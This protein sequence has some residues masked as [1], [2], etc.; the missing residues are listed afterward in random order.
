MAKEG[1]VYEFELTYDGEKVILT[2][3][4]DN[5]VL[6]TNVEKTGDE[7]GQGNEVINY[8]ISDVHNGSSVR[9]NNFKI[10]D[11]LPSEVRLQSIT[12]GTF[13]EDLTYKVQYTT[14][15]NNIKTIKNNLSTITDNSIDFTNEQL[16]NDEYITKFTFIFDSVK[17]NFKNTSDITVK[18]KVIEG[19]EKNSIF[20]NCV[21]V[22]GTYLNVTVEDKD[23][24]PTVVYENKIEINKAT[25][26]DNQYTNETK[27]T[28]MTGVKFDIF[29]ST[30]NEL[31]GQITTE[32]GY[33]E[34]KYLPIGSYY[35]VETETLDYYVLPENNRFKFEITKK[36]QTVILNIENDVVNLIVDV[37]KTGTVE[38]IPGGNLEYLFDIQNKSNDTVE[39]FVF[40]D[41]LPSEIRIDKIFTGTFNQKN[42]YKVQYITNNNSNWKTID[43]YSTKIN[44]EV[45]LSSSK[46]NLSDGEYVKEFRFVFD[47]PVEKGFKNSGTKITA[48]ANAD[49]INNQIFTNKTYI[50]A[51]YLAV[52]LSD[53]DEF[54][55]IVRIPEVENLTG[56]LP[57]TGK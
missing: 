39:N 10:E 23:C 57:R 43:T 38:T 6:E 35:A 45:D 44:N 47:N 56:V 8:Q 34:L 9:L 52:K 7:L 41:I 48:T 12:T 19:L 32:N 13:S 21:V 15:K 36:G 14:N 20:K 49:L 55:T 5:V 31:V 2:I 29:D 11:S 27:G 40:G 30:S 37:E 51:T 18:A 25:K 26:E 24:T 3:E 17:S 16:S 53:K 46:L 42:T 28:L 33:A 54:H 4:N 22:S 50:N 1:T